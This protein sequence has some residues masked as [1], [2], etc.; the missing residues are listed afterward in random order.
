MES[1]QKLT[2]LAA[3]VVTTAGKIKEATY[4]FRVRAVGPQGP[5]R[6]PATRHFTVS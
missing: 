1:S 2:T 6:N 4:T 5:D 3:A